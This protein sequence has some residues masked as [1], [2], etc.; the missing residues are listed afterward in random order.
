VSLTSLG[1]SRRSELEVA[2]VVVGAAVAAWLLT[3][4]GAKLQDGLRGDSLI[5]NLAFAHESWG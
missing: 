4:V 2:T 5:E 1:R 3:A